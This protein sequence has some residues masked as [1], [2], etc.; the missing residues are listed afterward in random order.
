MKLIAPKFWQKITLLSLMLWPLGLIYGLVSYIKYKKFAY[1]FNAKIITVGN[2]TIGGAGKTPV[3]ISLT[4][5]IN[6]KLAVLTRGYLGSLVGPIMVAPSHN[7]FS[8]GDE[9]LLLAK[10]APTCV[11]KNRLEGLKFL[12]SLGYEVIITD[13][14][15][16]DGRF[17]KALIISVVDSYQ[18]FGNGFVFPAGPLRE[19]LK[20]GLKRADF[21]AVIGE[22]EYKLPEESNVIKARLVANE[23]LKQQKFIAFAGIGN[24]EKFFLSVE[25]SGGE[26]IKKV[27][28]ADH[29]QYTDDELKELIDYAGKHNLKLITTEKDYMRISEEFRSEIQVL[30]VNLVWQDISEV[31]RYLGDI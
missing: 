21:M 25:E 5:I 19:Y 22:G 18:G 3:V 16:Q 7:V 20:I 11:A 24:P 6:K 15:M 30:V 27:A 14:G 10:H 9:A 23:N 2:I 28:F 26:V 8:V 13:D 31:K 4:T 12:E 17:C 29:H 1:K